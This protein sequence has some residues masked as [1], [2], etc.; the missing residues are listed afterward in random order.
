[1]NEARTR[2]LQAPQKEEH[3]LAIELV[4]ELILA[5]S[6]RSMVATVTGLG[7]GGEKVPRAPG[8][9]SVPECSGGSRF[10]A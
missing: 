1:M 3:N 2:M 9:Q 7:G 10:L 6:D 4:I 8:A 5:D